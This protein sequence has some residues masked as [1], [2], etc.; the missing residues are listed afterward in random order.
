MKILLI[1][2]YNEGA[3]GISVQVELLY[4]NLLKENNLSKFSF[5]Y[6]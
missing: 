6:V 5:T 2:N 1:A 3:G 4:K